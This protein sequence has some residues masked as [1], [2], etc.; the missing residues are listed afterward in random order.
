MKPNALSR[1]VS[2]GTPR[3]NSFVSQKDEARSPCDGRAR[4]TSDRYINRHELRALIPASDMT[5]WR[6]MH[7]PKVGFPAPVKLSP[8]GRNFWWLPA[9]RD[10]E[11]RR[12]D[13]SAS[14]RRE[15]S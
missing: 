11:R 3:D 1:T 6:W 14:S 4:A 7:D 8:N 9:I 5:I 12:R 2:D 13:A 10:W 15:A